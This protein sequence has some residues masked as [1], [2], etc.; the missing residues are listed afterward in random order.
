MLGHEQ[1]KIGIYNEIF[2]N[3]YNTNLNKR[4]LQDL[5]LLE[6]EGFL[7][8]APFEPFNFDFCVVIIGVVDKLNPC[9][10]GHIIYRT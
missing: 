1:L 2:E 7:S 9:A 6:M 5:N 8:A 4:Y 3:Y 10:Y